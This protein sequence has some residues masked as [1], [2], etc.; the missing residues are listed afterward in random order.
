MLTL[1]RPKQPSNSI[2][3]LAEDFFAFGLDQEGRSQE[4]IV[5]WR[6]LL[7]GAPANDPWVAVAHQA[8]ARLEGASP[9][10]P[11][12]SAADVEGAETLSAEERMVMIGGMV[13]ALAARLASDPDDAGGWA[14]L[15]RS[16]MVLGRAVEASAALETAR[17]AFAADTGKLAI[18][19]TEARTLGLIE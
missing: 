7:A 11:G 14:R 8:L 17:Q 3:F 4:A 12:P 10:V 6:D 5:A 13:D 15:I 18:V 16:Y 19:E 2:P 9:G 1:N